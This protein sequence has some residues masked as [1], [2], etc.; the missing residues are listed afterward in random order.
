MSQ[1]VSKL[2][3]NV[4][5]NMIHLCEFPNFGLVRYGTVTNNI[6]IPYHYLYIRTSTAFYRILYHVT[7]IQKNTYV[8]S[9]T[10]FNIPA[11]SKL[12]IISQM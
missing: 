12:L 6:M 2:N 7:L 9:G 4:S 10:A 1:N 5:K 8:R 3:I 11:H